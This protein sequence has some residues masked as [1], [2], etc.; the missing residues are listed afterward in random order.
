MEVQL[1]KSARAIQIRVAVDKSEPDHVRWGVITSSNWYNYADA[2]WQ[3]HESETQYLFDNCLQGVW[4]TD[5]ILLWLRKM[6]FDI[7]FR[8]KWEETK[9]QEHIDRDTCHYQNIRYFVDGASCL[10]LEELETAIS[11]G[12]QGH[13]L[14]S[15]ALVSGTIRATD[16]CYQKDTW[17]A[18]TFA[19]LPGTWVA[20]CLT[21]PT[22]WHHRVKELLIRHESAPAAIFSDRAGFIKVGSAGVDSG[23]CGFFDENR[24]PTDKEEFEYEEGRFYGDCCSLTLDKQSPGG[25]VIPQGFGAVTSSGFGDGSYPVF[26]LTNDAG[27]AIAAVIV[28]IGDDEVGE[29]PDDESAEDE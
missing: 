8:L 4:A 25:G 5:A 1:T 6:S 14:G 27:Q 9:G 10:T 7:G 3:E 2:E 11:P 19:S 29:E 12:D 23:Q 13:E 24:Y 20:E 21:G 22:D 15:L 17:C 18:L 16:P 26:T 28:F